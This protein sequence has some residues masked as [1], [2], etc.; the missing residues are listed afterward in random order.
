MRKGRGKA[1]V[2]KIGFPLTVLH[3][4]ILEKK[5]SMEKYGPSNKKAINVLTAYT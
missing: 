4:Y 2:F 1:P 3:I 5:N